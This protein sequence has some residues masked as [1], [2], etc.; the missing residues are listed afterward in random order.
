MRKEGQTSPSLSFQCISLNNFTTNEK[1]NFNFSNFLFSTKSG[2][3][4]TETIRT[5]YENHID[6]Y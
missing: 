5:Y 4:A 1:D 2:I 3:F 6:T